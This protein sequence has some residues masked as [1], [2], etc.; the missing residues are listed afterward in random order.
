MIHTWLHHAADLMLAGWVQ[1]TGSAGLSSIQR[2]AFQPVVSV[3]GVGAGLAML[4][5]QGWLES[6]AP[7]LSN[8]AA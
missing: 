6:F 5:D 3:V 1:D 4:T 7:F 8:T 2:S